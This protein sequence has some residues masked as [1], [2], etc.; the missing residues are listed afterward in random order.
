MKKPNI[1]SYSKTA[2]P[3]LEKLISANEKV[4]EDL[5]GRLVKDVIAGKSLL[6]FGS[7]HSAIFP[8]EL[9][10]RA[11]GASF[12]LP[13]VADFLLPTAGPSVVRVLERTA[14]VAQAV[15]ARA[16]PKKGEMLW[17][18]SNS[19][20]NAAVV[21]LAITAK[22]MGLYTVAFTSLAHSKHVESRHTSGK[23]LFEVTDQ[24]VDIGGV[25]GDASVEIADGVVAG[26]LSSMSTILLGHSILT[27]A[28][29]ELEAK[30][31]SCTY[32][33]VNTPEGEARNRGLEK[34][35]A[36]RDP[37]LR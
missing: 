8:L 10:H 29:G 25:R 33:S 15:L 34:T 4:M 17:L 1:Y 18:A 11:G 27:A 35:A 13:V 23:R 21:D 24:V 14:G 9:Y 31:H 7:G 36:L 12:V 22:K 5:V 32:T 6:I 37:L 20:I 28:M 26:P 2:L 3:H 16:E 19:G 30:G